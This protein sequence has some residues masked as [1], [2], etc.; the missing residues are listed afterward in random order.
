MSGENEAKKHYTSN[1]NILF[2]ELRIVGRK[3]KAVLNRSQERYCYEN[4]LYPIT[5]SFF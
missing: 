4:P 3:K 1:W 2:Q 5:E